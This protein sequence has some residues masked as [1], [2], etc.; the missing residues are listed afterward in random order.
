MET[1]SGDSCMPPSLPWLSSSSSK[2]AYARGSASRDTARRIRP[3]GQVCRC[4]TA[5]DRVT[6]TTN[7]TFWRS[8][9]GSS[10]TA[11]GIRRI[12]RSSYRPARARNCRQSTCRAQRSGSATAAIPPRLSIQSSPRRTSCRDSSAASSRSAATANAEAGSVAGVPGP[13]P[14]PPVGSWFARSQS[15]ALR[16]SSAEPSGS[17]KCRATAEVAVEMAAEGRWSCQEPSGR[18]TANSCWAAES[19][20]LRTWAG[21]RAPDAITF[22]P[23]TG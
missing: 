21:G 12:R 23:G 6:G 8:F 7:D 18:R 19:M 3:C 17:A 14:Q 15:S 9:R 16:I 4:I 11:A 22:T 1:S 10:A 13:S 5:Q 20:A 2:Y